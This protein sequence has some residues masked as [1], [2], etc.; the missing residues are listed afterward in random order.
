MKKIEKKIE[1][2]F[3]DKEIPELSIQEQ[4]KLRNLVKANKRNNK[5]QIFKRVAIYASAFCLVL[6]ML[7]PT[8]ML[9]NKKETPNKPTPTVYYGK[10]EATKKDLTIEETQE[11]ISNSYAKYNFIFTELSFLSSVGY[12]IPNN[13]SLLAIQI[14]ANEIESPYTVIE[15]HL[16]ISK[17]FIFD[18]HDEYLKDSSYTQ[19]SNYKL[20]KKSYQDSFSENMQGY[21]IFDTHQLYI[22]LNMINE[23]LFN[24]FL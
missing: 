11:V 21:I 20:Y 18:K 13:D 2:Y 7:I 6:L 1:Q 22:S 9:I 4:D 17:Q 14:K 24:K 19:N 15:I 23:S 5:T 10:D 3:E 16:I 12:Y 8:I